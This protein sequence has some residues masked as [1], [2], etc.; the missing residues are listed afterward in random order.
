[1]YFLKSISIKKKKGMMCM[2]SASTQNRLKNPVWS[3]SLLCY[4]YFPEAEN[5]ASASLPKPIWKLM[6]VIFLGNLAL[7][8]MVFF[9]I[10]HLFTS[11]KDGGGLTLDRRWSCL[12]WTGCK[13]STVWNWQISHK[14]QILTGQ[15]VTQR[16]YFWAER[17][18][19]K[20]KRFKA[21][22]LRDNL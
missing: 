14:L 7:A 2:S 15:E 13:F 6:F 19:R 10:H 18:C 3:F 11:V 17:S 4:K 12:A 16:N 1:M 9:H 20:D 5:T 8:C 21:G 22:D